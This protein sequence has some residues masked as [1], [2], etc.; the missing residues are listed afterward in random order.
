MFHIGTYSMVISSCILSLCYAYFV[1][2]W[3][4]ESK[5]AKDITFQNLLWI[6][7]KI[8]KKC[9][10]ISYN[11]YEE[12]NCLSNV[13]Q[14]IKYGLYGFSACTLYICSY[15]LNVLEWNQ[16]IVLYKHEM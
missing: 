8:W 6:I 13:H 7:N 3:W 2:L 14:T 5:T 10:V 4:S 15:L 11:I 12:F 9:I 1:D 16:W